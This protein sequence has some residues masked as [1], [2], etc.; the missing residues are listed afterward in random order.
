MVHSVLYKCRTAKFLV[1]RGL[2]SFV[3]FYLCTMKQSE[4]M[5][6]ASKHPIHLGYDEVVGL[7]LAL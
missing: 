4:F 5:L 6:H 3:C 1:T 7:C 2:I